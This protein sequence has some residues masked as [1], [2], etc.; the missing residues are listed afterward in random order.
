MWGQETVSYTICDPGVDGLPGT[1]DELCDS[2]DVGITVNGWPDA[3]DDNE[4]TDED[5]TK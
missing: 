3:V 2:A 1:G 4:M 5:V